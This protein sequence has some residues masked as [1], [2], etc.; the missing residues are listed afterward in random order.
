ME[1][2]QMPDRKSLQAAVKDINAVLEPKPKIP[3]I[4]TVEN[5]AKQIVDSIAACIGEGD[6]GP[7]WT[8]QR[9]SKLKDE[10]INVYKGILAVGLPGEATEGATSEGAETTEGAEGTEEC[11]AFLQSLGPNEGEEA[12]TVCSRFTECKDKHE[13]AKAQA[14]NPEKPKKKKEAKPKEPK[15]AIYT[16]AESVVDAL[17]TGNEFTKDELAQAANDL[18]KA[19]GGKDNVKESAGDVKRVLN[20]LGYVGML[21]ESEGKFRKT[22]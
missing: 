20:I 6:D 14:S 2:A 1:Q 16:R 13:A 17:N 3:F 18:Y 7:V 21:S 8:D 19:K 11:E 10:T 15:K 4:T 9:A 5:M 12:C 22:V